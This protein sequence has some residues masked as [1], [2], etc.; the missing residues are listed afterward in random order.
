MLYW[1][2]R[3]GRQLEREDKKV[4]A[5]LDSLEKLMGDAVKDEAP[6]LQEVPKPRCPVCQKDI[7]PGDV[8]EMQGGPHA[9]CGDPK[10]ENHQ[11]IGE[12]ERFGYIGD[13]GKEHW[14]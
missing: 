3:I 7:A 2:I 6:P 5:D 9:I 11:R 4:D 14:L 1:G 8:V 12:G 10:L 13:D